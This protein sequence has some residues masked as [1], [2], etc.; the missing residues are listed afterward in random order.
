MRIVALDLGVK[1][2]TYCELFHGQVVRRTT[3]TEVHSLRPLLGPDQPRAEVAI[4]ACREA[5]FVYD[6]L[7]EWG[8]QVVVV[9]T[10]RRKQV[11]IGQ[12]R[13]KNDRI[14]AEIL[15]RALE[16]G[17]IPQAHV[18][19]PQRRDLRRVLGVRRALV[20]ARAQFVTT[21][22]G[23]VREQGGK[24]PSCEV[25][26]FSKKVRAQKLPP[27][28]TQ[29]IEPLLVLVENIDRQLASTE[30]QLATLCSQEPIIAAL[31]TT[32]GVGMIVAACFVSVVDEA[33]R[34]HKAHEVESYVGLVPSEDTSGGKRR[35]G[36]I[37]KQGNSY[38]R[39]L[40]VQ[41]GWGVLRSRDKND[42]LYLW[43]TKLAK[44]R[45]KRIAVVALARRL[46]GVLW[47]MWRDGTVY[48]AQYLAQQGVH[49]LRGA[50]QSLEQQKAALIRAA[51][52]ASVKNMLPSSPAT[53]RRSPKTPAA[54]AA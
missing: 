20:E 5:W 37:S 43:G 6:L 26:N 11:G 30:E 29:L 52:K 46:A 54:N 14:D 22:R 19:S 23:L 47:A 33:K 1:K 32:P 17:R 44:L 10:T 21:A 2:T 28:V 8:N 24:I 40:L 35:V 49:G 13:R 45:G 51:K 36:A 34:F 27:D 31:T 9:D 38:L 15:A 41:A 16:A 42:P 18:L 53:S 12:H 4:E 48:D 25:E 3:V 50:V 7:T 39:A